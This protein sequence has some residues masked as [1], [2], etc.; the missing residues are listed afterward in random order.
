M[1]EFWH[2]TGR[3]TVAAGNPA[4]L[5]VVAADPARLPPAE[6]WH[7][8]VLGTLLG[9]RWTYRDDTLG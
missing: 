1:G 4:D 8:P 6:L 9:G 2:R 5:V 7:V 3:Q